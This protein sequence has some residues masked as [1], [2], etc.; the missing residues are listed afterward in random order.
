MCATPHLLLFTIPP[1]YRLF[2]LKRPTRFPRTHLITTNNLLGPSRIR[3]RARTRNIVGEHRLGFEVRREGEGKP[4][5]RMVHSFVRPAKLKLFRRGWPV[6]QLYPHKG[7][8]FWFVRRWNVSVPLGSAR[9]DPAA[10]RCGTGPP[11]RWN[12]R[13]YQRAQL[14]SEGGPDAGTNRWLAGNN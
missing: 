13:E 1:V 6:T 4:G 14:I 7:T 5:D 2:R 10:R 11:R 9:L 8:C 12:D 3:P